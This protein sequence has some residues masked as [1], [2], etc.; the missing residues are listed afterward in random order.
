VNQIIT[1]YIAERD[2]RYVEHTSDGAIVLDHGTSNGGREI[3]ARD[4]YWNMADPGPDAVFFAVCDTSITAISGRD[5]VSTSE[6]T[7][8]L[9]DLRRLFSDYVAKQS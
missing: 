5:L 3:L 7:D 6:M 2:P 4:A 8:V 9:L 1:D